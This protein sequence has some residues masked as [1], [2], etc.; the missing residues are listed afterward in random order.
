MEY[1]GTPAY[2]K[3]DTNGHVTLG[4][5]SSDYNIKFADGVL[6]LNNATIIYNDKEYMGAIVAKQSLTIEL[7][8][9]TTNTVTNNVNRPGAQISVGIFTDY[10][11]LTIQGRGT[12]NVTC[13]ATDNDFSYGIKS[14][15]L[16]IDG[17]TVK[18]EGCSARYN[19]SGLCINYSLTMKNHANVTAC[20]GEGKEKSYGIWIVNA[21]QKDCFIIDRS[22]GSA[23][24]TAASAEEKAAICIN[25]GYTATLTDASITS[26]SYS[27]AKM[28]WTAN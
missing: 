6:T 20:A 12:L 16:V 9:G 28:S 11:D 1:A 26:G 18:A 4:G 5:N 24:T 3:T 10:Y 17:A 2:A 7:I 23:E 19:S 15:N 27:G 14:Q 21:Y 13:N 22:S 25:K 8:K